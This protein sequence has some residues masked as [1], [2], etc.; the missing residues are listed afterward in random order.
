MCNFE[1]PQGKIR[2][3]DPIFQKHYHMNATNSALLYF[4]MQ[5]I[6]CPLPL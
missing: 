3:S 1:S 5:N 6:L 4:F 2:L